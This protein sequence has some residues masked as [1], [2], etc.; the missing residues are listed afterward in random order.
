MPTPT[1]DDRHM[2]ND[3]DVDVDY[4]DNFQPIADGGIDSQSSDFPRNSN[5]TNNCNKY[6]RMLCQTKIGSYN[7]IDR[8]FRHRQRNDAAFPYEM[9]SENEKKQMRVS[10]L[11]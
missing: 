10:S 9:G 1:I 7:E 4:E 8:V 5:A 11:R 2:D 6:K 3:N